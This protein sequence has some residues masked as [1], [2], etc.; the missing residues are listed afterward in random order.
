MNMLSPE[1]FGRIKKKIKLLNR[2]NRF[3]AVCLVIACVNL[4][5]LFFGVNLIEWG[6]NTAL[7][8]AE[9]WGPTI[10]STF[11]ELSKILSERASS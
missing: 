7:A 6:K 2:L 9:K 4:V 8:A 5:L 10:E 11:N 1:E 3:L